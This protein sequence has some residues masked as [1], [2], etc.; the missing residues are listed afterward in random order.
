[1]KNAVQQK[2]YFFKI[3]AVFALLFCLQ[4]CM[5]FVGHP[6]Q[7]KADDIDFDAFSSSLSQMR[8][9]YDKT[10]NEI[11]VA[12]YSVE[13]TDEDEQLPTRL[14]VYS[15]EDID[16]FGA[17]AKAEYQ[18]VHIFQYEDFELA[19]NAYQYYKQNNNVEDVIF[20]EAITVDD[21]EVETNAT[22]Y[23]SWGAKFVGY[24][25]FTTTLNETVT[26][27]EPVVVA[28]LDS[29]IYSSHEL[30][31]G[32]ILHQY[33]K[34]FTDEVSNTA[35]AYEDLNG[36]G[37]HV[38]GIIA[39]ATE[40][41]VKILPLKV[42]DCN[43][44]GYVS[45]IVQAIKYVE[46]LVSKNTL[47]IQLINMSIG[48]KRTASVDS[49]T[50]NNASLSYQ[51]QSA[52]NK[53]ILSIVS[54]GNDS[55]NT[56]YCSPANVDCA[57][58]VSALYLYTT[59]WPK[60]ETLYFDSSYSNYGSHVD[61]SAPGTDIYS[62]SRLGSNLYV[63]MSGTSMA[64]PHVTACY[65]LVRSHPS[66][67]DISNEDLNLIMQEN[68]ID[69][70]EQGHDIYYGYGCINIANIGIL[71]SG[72]VEFSREEEF[73]DTSFNLTLTYDESNIK[74]G[75]SV[76]I[77]YTTNE[78]ATTIDSN[79][80]KLYTGP[81]K[82]SQ[83]TKIT[84]VAFVYNQ[85]NVLVQR[86]TVS[87]KVY[88][89][90]NL[91][92][93]SN[94]EVQQV[95]L[96]EVY[97]TKYNG[98]LTTLNVPIL[99]DGKIV[100]GISYRAFNSSKVEILNLP[101]TVVN[102]F[103]SAF[104]NNACIKQINCEASNVVVGESA[105][106]YSTI[107][108]FNVLK[109]ETV[110]AYA[111]ANCTALQE[112]VLP[113][114]VDIGQHA[115]SASAI[116]NLLIGQYV[117]FIGV[118]TDLSINYV[119]G[120]INTVAKTDF[121]DKYNLN[122]VDLTFRI[123]EDLKEK[124]IISSAEDLKLNMLVSGVGIN[125]F[126]S[127]SGDTEKLTFDYENVADYTF[128][129]NINFVDLTEGEYILSVQLTDLY[130]NNIN[131][132]SCKIVVVEPTREKYTIN[133]QEGQFDVFVDGELITPNTQLYTGFDY[134]VQILPKDGYTLDN[135]L[136]NG[137]TKSEQFT[138]DSSISSGQ[139]FEITTKEV[140]S[141]NVTFEYNISYGQIIVDDQPAISTVVDR[142][143]DLSFT[144]NLA[145]GYNVSRVYVDE[146]VISPVNGVYTINNL[147]TDKH[148]EVEF[149]K[150]YYK[151]DITQGNGGS[152]YISGA[153]QDMVE[154][155]SSVTLLLSASEG[156]VLDSVLLNGEIAEVQDDK[157]VL[158]NIDQ[159]YEVVVQ[160]AKS[161]ENIFKDAVLVRYFIVLLIIFV[162]F[163]LAKLILYF[164]RKEKNKK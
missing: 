114:I 160:F 148:V 110:E 54:A 164:A 26:T 162:I 4:F 120:F 8:Q 63:S 102:I 96:T 84:A 62:A 29:G 158:E 143:D 64:A 144:I 6:S 141:V 88:Y 49:V 32:R 46:E 94:Y 10:N 65:A 69:L 145:D 112:L 71:T 19:E 82:I 61:F 37:T 15:Q 124:K 93:A 42:L 34:N 76:K 31:E 18:D 35:Y 58:T 159:D 92:L 50:A 51:I 103:E 122:F 27:L 130:G 115:F 43:G 73:C 30:F 116:N 109:T 75:Y 101:Y 24:S 149:E 121:A 90:D 9:K 163:V 14:I 95:S 21:I 129:L 118:Q 107:E 123:E 13:E 87:S 80:D 147:L 105:F 113:Y 59:T 155:G 70:G 52:Y 57:V 134:N 66:Y 154:Y 67:S 146:Q 83:T 39:N 151:I 132:Q 119:Y 100:T 138:L 47:D 23:K 135:V 3:M 74:E 106:R 89:F 85:S 48:V 44:D 60:T 45:M 133:Y 12:S 156:Y 157:L 68:A 55:I 5:S 86:S 20:D 78:T 99:I 150:K 79:S 25:E 7:V 16:D 131:A 38:A 142:G 153:S 81:I 137:T 117:N 161:N 104:Y 40:S 128:K 108:Q 111:F 72:E 126:Y 28:V 77:Y 127:F 41:N 22:S 17:V 140:A 152:I 125:C 139:N 11:Q 33:A 97:I 36:H 56:L 91:D 53:G 98:V 136:V 1:M 2:K